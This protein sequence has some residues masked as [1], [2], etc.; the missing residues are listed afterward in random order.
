MIGIMKSIRVEMKEG[1][2]K[3]SQELKGEMDGLRQEVK[4]QSTT[5]EA[6]MKVIADK[7]Y[8]SSLRG[9]KMEET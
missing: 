8:S 1:Q 5:S 3:L 2:K 4:N 6:Q 9:E 7:V